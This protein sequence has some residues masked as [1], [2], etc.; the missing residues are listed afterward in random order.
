M[1]VDHPG[2]PERGAG[3]PYFAERER[4]RAAAWKQA[5]TTLPESA[6]LPAPYMRNGTAPMGQYS[7]CLP[8]AHADHNLL[9]DV[10]EVALEL[11]REL[12]IRWHASV[13]GGPS[14]HL[15]DSQVQCV[16]ALGRMVTEPA[17]IDLAFRDVVDIAE[18]LEVEP[19]RFLTF[20][21]V[22]PTD[23]LH[24]GKG[25]PLRRG[26]KCTSIDAA[27]RYRTSTGA[28]ELA[29]V[30]WKYTESYLGAERG[31]PRATRT[32]T[33]RYRDLYQAPDGPLHSELVP[34]ED[35]LLEPFYQLMRQQL[36]AR[37]LEKDPDFP[38]EVVRVLHVLSR[39]NQAYQESLPCQTHRALGA[40]VDQI[41]ARLLRAT[42]R[43]VRVD[44]EVFL[45]PEI[46][47]EEYSR[48]YGGD[49]DE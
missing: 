25:E 41:W 39:D 17:R 22:S 12:D 7:Y 45:D 9:P 21:L 3:H 26:S 43:Y 27:F 20:E 36:L 16:N 49:P 15:L 2:E 8:V 46:T 1:T 23:H 5:T 14:N 47:S 37:E 40:S 13:R 32:R 33:A 29:L 48:R 30:E 35:M 18:V 44:P 11:F 24:E 10:R 28:T 4:A 34:F 19:G 38:A 31:G 42:D 6:R